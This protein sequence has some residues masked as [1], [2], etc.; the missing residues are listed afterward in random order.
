MAGTLPPPNPTNLC[1][2]FSFRILCNSTIPSSLVSIN[3]SLTGFLNG[4]PNYNGIYSGVTYGVSYL[5]NEYWYF[6]N[7]NIPT[8]VIFSSTTIGDVPCDLIFVPVNTTGTN[9]CTGYTS[10]TIIG[11]QSLN[12]SVCSTIDTFIGDTLSCKQIN[13]TDNNT[14]I[15]Y[16]NESDVLLQ[17]TANTG[18]E[19]VVCS[20]GMPILANEN[21]SLTPYGSI[22][23]LSPTTY[24]CQTFCNTGD[25]CCLN[26]TGT[27]TFQPYIDSTFLYTDVI[28]GYI[29]PTGTFNGKPFYSFKLWQIS[30]TPLTQG[31]SAYIIYDNGRWELYEFNSYGF[32]DLTPPNNVAYNLRAFTTGGTLSCPGYGENWVMTGTPYTYNSSIV[33]LTKFITSISNCPTIPTSR[34]P[35]IY[36]NSPVITTLPLGVSCE[37]INATTN[38]TNNGEI[39]LTITGGTPPYSIMFDDG[40]NSTTT[41][42]TFIRSGLYSRTYGIKISDV[43]PDFTENIQCT[44]G[45]TNVVT[46][47]TTTTQQIPLVGDPTT[48]YV[49]VQLPSPPIQGYVYYSISNQPTNNTQPYPNNFVWVRHNQLLTYPQCDSFI[50]ASNI[51]LPLGYT[52]YIQIRDITGTLIYKTIKGFYQ[53]FPFEDP[54]SGTYQYNPAYFTHPH[55]NNGPASKV[56]K[57]AFKIIYPIETVPAP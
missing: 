51:N 28:K 19:V 56:D 45:I 55:I 12:S 43:Y 11:T 13:I 15:F 20:N 25:Y 6:Y 40:F 23:T 29:K 31:T 35:D 8:R 48:I 17:M 5:N 24:K 9:F 52:I 7:T 18:D 16:K 33:G 47:T 14:S 49:S 46:T 42:T 36:G 2:C 44:V 4:R 21:T 54:C 10:N 22:S 34:C 1:N 39:E 26:F 41:F 30:T 37:S 57:L 50:A 38:L 53:G 32:A 3:M 27:T